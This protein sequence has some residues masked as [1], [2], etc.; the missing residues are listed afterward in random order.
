MAKAAIPVYNLRNALHA[1][2]DPGQP[3]DFGYA[4]LPETRRIAGFELY[5]NRGMLPA[6]GPI[7][8]SFYRMGLS[9]RGTCDVQLGLEHFHHEDGTVN[10]TFPNQ[11][12]S[13]ANLSDDAFG[14]YLLFETDFLNELV[15][16]MQIGVEF[17]F[18]CFNGVPFFKFNAAELAQIEA[19]ILKINEELH[20]DQPGREKAIKMYVYLI[21]LEC[22]RSY[23]RQGLGN[24]AHL[25]E[26]L[27]LVRRFRQLVSEHF[28]SHHQVADY[29]GMLHV[30]PNHLNRTI[31]DNTGQTASDLIA[32]MQLQEARSLLRYT[33]MS[34]AEIGYRLSFSDPSSFNRFFRKATGQTPLDYK[35]AYFGLSPA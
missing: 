2:R 28:L 31:K 29:A 4:S 32:A 1:H 13:K 14:Y 33:D 16:A 25:S 26:A 30:T 7:R 27:R 21:L 15:P 35:K 17:P 5:S 22:R 10:F 9:M 12:F 34:A 8:S 3:G 19:F 20:G 24:E 23:D 6:I 11:V 18:F